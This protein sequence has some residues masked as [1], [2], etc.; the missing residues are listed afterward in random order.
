[1]KF[2]FIPILA[3]Y[4]GCATTTRAADAEP[5]AVDPVMPA[6]TQR[7]AAEIQKEMKVTA[8]KLNEVLPSPGLIGD[9]RFR[10]ENGAKAVPVLRRLADLQ[11]ELAAAQGGEWGLALET[12]RLQTLGRAMAAG[13]KDAEK[14]LTEAAASKDAN[15]ALRAKSALTEG[16]WLLNSEDAGA[17]QKLLDDYA[18]VA[19]ANPD[20][21]VVAQT[22]M[23]MS[24]L[25][26]ANEEM[27]GKALEV[28]RTNMKGYM[29]RARELSRRVGDAG[30]LRSISWGCMGWAAAHNNQ[31][32]DH[33]ARLV[34]EGQLTPA[35]LVSMRLAITP[36]LVMTDELKKLA[37]ADID[38][39]T[40]R[41]DAHCDFIYLG[42]GMASGIDSSVA[43]AMEKPTPHLSEGI[44]IAFQDG[45]VQ[46]VKWPA[47]R[48]TLSRTNIYRKAHNL[49]EIDVDTLLK[50]APAQASTLRLSP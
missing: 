7:G 11:G 30:N 42:K 28:M 33:L 16:N 18:A 45:H 15:E 10:K 9:A 43:V 41:V 23:E 32:P 12:M 6:A 39:F 19:K 48:D 46:F 44:N 17:Q 34:A 40:R 3:L 36:E 35:M 14:K 20:S 4:I 26:P 22:L 47:V 31:Y 25:G 49:P 21:A 8:A 1:M 13:D 24:Q 5:A 38:G 27:S 37:A 50:S 29:V 2:T